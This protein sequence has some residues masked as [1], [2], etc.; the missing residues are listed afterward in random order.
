LK[1]NTILQ[2]VILILLCYNKDI[3]E[4]V[5]VMMSWINKVFK[6]KN[7]TVHIYGLEALRIENKEIRL[8]ASKVLAQTEQKLK[9]I[10]VR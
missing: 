6:P 2:G 1:N 10:G 4:G 8:S 7:A 9:K 3:F 5:G